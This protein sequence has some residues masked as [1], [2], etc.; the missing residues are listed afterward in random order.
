MDVFFLALPIAS[1]AIFALARKGGGGEGGGGRGG[2]LPKKMSQTAQIVTKQSK[3]NE[4]NTMQKLR[5]T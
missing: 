1:R 3:R 2:Y 5:P 4:G